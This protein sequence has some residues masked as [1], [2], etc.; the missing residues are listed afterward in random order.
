[1]RADRNNTDPSIS[2]SVASRNGT[3]GIEIAGAT[4]VLAPVLVD[5]VADLNGVA[6]IRFSGPVAGAKISRTTAVANSV[7]IE[8]TG[9]DTT[10]A[11]ISAVT[12]AGND[13]EGML[14]RATASRL[15]QV[16]ADGNEGSGITLFEGGGGNTIK[17]STA[18]A[19]GGAGI[20]LTDSSANV[21]Q[22][23]VALGNAT[24][25]LRDDSPGCDSNSWKSNVFRA[26]SQPC[27]H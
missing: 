2:H 12:M 14:L 25:D 16:H 21:I 20:V 10:A 17:K 1:M 6:G 24:T 3:G 7:G 15:Q 13:G 19:N 8:T 11:K 18:G 23:D 22:K 9:G 5:V 4:G 26:G 27:I